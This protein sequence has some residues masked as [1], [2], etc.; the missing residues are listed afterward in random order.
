MPTNSTPSNVIS[1]RF[2]YWNAV[3]GP[4]GSGAIRPV[5]LD[6]GELRAVANAAHCRGGLLQLRR[7]GGPD[8]Q[9]D[10]WG[11]DNGELCDDPDR[12]VDSDLP[13]RQRRRPQDLHWCRCDRERRVGREDD[14][15]VLQPDGTY[16]YQLESTTGQIQ[17]APAR[18]RVVIN[19]TITAANFTASQDGLEFNGA[20]GGTVNYT[21]VVPLTM[22]ETLV[23]KNQQGQVVR[24][25]VP[26]L[27]RAGGTYVDAWNGRNDLGMLVP[28]GPYFYV[29]TVFNGINNFVWDLSTQY[30][31]DYFANLDG[32]PFQ[33]FDPLNNRP[34]TFTYNFGATGKRHSRGLQ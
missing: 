3:T 16:T 10:P 8:L 21:S 23:V 26:G 34:L 27:Q 22:T 13:Q 20:S 18:G 2:D 6:W 4:G 7:R 1:C 30:R 11:H 25:L 14:G 31:N 33:G 29:A 15:G 19:T 24:T 12:L 9:P 5:G 17:A 28:D 32:V